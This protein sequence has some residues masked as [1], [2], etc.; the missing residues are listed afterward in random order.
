MK[1]CIIWGGKGL[2]KMVR[3]ILER[4]G[5]KVLAIFDNDP[6]VQSPFSD[7]PI[8]GGWDEFLRYRPSLGD[9]C[10]FVAAI[11]ANGKDRC[12]ISQ[13]LSSFGLRPINVIHETAYVSATASFGE[14]IQ[15]MPMAAICETTRFGAYCL[16]NTNSSV[17]HGCSIGDGF[18]AMPG[19]T[20]AGEVTIGNYVSIG[21]N[22]TVL[23]RLRIG[24]GATIGAGAVVTK[25][26]SDQ[27]TVVGNPARTMKKRNAKAP[28]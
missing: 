10:G 25:D 2:A 22:A 16:L 7:L 27:C 9:E 24:H 23:P 8:R 15:V 26:V 28:G 14:G 4:D 11:G 18:H 12:A 13:K 3:P 19:A 21:S 5:H 17:D 20:I 1:K 6:R